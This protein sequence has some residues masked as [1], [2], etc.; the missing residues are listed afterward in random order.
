MTTPEHTLVGIHLALATGRDRAWGWRAVALA[1]LA[2]NAPDWDGLTLLV[3]MA[4]FDR[5]HRVWGHNLAAICLVSAAVA[6]LVSRWDVI[7]GAA[8]R[9]TALLRRA[10][11]SPAGGPVP[12]PAAAAGRE[13]H[14]HG[15]PGDDGPLAFGAAFLTAAVAQAVHLP[16]D[17]VVSGGNGLSH[18]EVRP[19]WPFSAVGC[20][21]PLIPWGDVGPTLILMAGIVVAASGRRG[22]AATSAATLALLVAYLVVRGATA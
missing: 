14:G 20:V 12:P 3:D 4:W 16:C 18:W 11:L 19:F 1:G 10:G 21:W 7:G 2:S 15:G 5:G 6:A 22:V 9:A 17:M 13:G 8:T